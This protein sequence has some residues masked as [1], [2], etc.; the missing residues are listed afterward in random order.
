[1]VKSKISATPM[2]WD[3]ERIVNWASI[4]C[5]RVAHGKDPRNWK[6]VH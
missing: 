4:G 1:L 6:Q 3:A 5:E 2:G